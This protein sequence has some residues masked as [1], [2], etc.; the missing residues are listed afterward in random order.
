M[1]LLAMLT[2]AGAAG[3]ALGPLPAGEA[4]AGVTADPAATG[5]I[6]DSTPVAETGGMGISAREVLLRMIFTEGDA[7]LK[8]MLTRRMLLLE[9]A[10][11]GVTVSAQELDATLQT[12]L[13]TYRRELAVAHPDEA[14]TLTDEQIIHAR[15][16]VSL[17]TYRDR[18]LYYA[19]LLQHLVIHA[20]DLTPQKLQAWYAA[21]ADRYGT[22]TRYQVREI[23]FKFFNDPASVTVDSPL[24][25]EFQQGLRAA[26]YLRAQKMAEQVSSLIKAGQ[27]FEEM[28]HKY[29]EESPA[30]KARGGALPIF[31]ANSPLDESFI[32]AARHLQQGET[33][34][35]VRSAFGYHLIHMDHIYP[36]KHP[37]YDEIE[38]RVR[39]DCIRQLA[40]QRIGPL[41]EGL[42]ST[43][44]VTHFTHLYP[45]PGEDLAAPTPETDGKVPIAECVA[46]I[47]RVEPDATLVERNRAVT[48]K[49]FYAELW[50]SVGEKII[51]ERSVLKLYMRS[52][53]NTPAEPTAIEF[54]QVFSDDQ[55]NC[56]SLQDRAIDEARKMGLPP[57][58]RRKFYDYMRELT[59]HTP[60]EL[61]EDARERAALW[62]YMKVNHPWTEDDLETYFYIEKER[63]DIPGTLNLDAIMVAPRRTGADGKVEVVDGAKATPA[64]WKA[65]AARAQNLYD[66]LRGGGLPLDTDSRLVPDAISW[67]TAAKHDSDL[68]PEVC[69]AAGTLAPLTVVRVVRPEEIS[70]VDANHSGYEMDVL[71]FDP[72]VAEVA[73]Q[74]P[75]HQVSAPVRGLA[76]YYI[77]RRES[78]TP[79]L[80]RSFDDPHVRKQVERDY[81]APRILTDIQPVF[82]QLQKDNPLTVHEDLLERLEAVDQPH[83]G[84]AR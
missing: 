24:H 74:L 83:L 40:A 46:V 76:G 50:R 6:L 60:A 30:V 70:V 5:P 14:R 67:N 55:E 44:E 17:A 58:P 81:V 15:F 57:P 66:H 48:R 35:P 84:A 53:R 72:A 38:A 80:G 12:D 52:I 27:A 71:N 10:K 49:E 62:K 79:P 34:G 68:S 43:T 45:A 65:A 13:A 77:L 28:E 11:R 59:G 51:K 20:D 73:L 25:R 75:D 78:Y 23:L 33:S 31:D 26:A 56:Y 32:A 7:A 42:S 1:S 69:A 18:E 64:E 19:L 41:V 39:A 37:P 22:P 9:A 82:D 54:S 2:I 4:D 63:Y 8:R 36:G 29:S 21:N 61:Q 3:G 16:R 47:G